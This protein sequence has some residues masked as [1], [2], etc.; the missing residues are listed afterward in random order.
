MAVRH[1]SAVDAFIEFMTSLPP[2]H[3]V[4]A[5]QIPPTDQARVSFLLN[6]N[7]ERRLNDE[8]LVELDEYERLE[9]MIRR[10]KIHAFQRLNAE[11]A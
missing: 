11:K 3:E 5:Y 10:A 9:R 8:E 2:I 1:L 7:G 6:A 4:V